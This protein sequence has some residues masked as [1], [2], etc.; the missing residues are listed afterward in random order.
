MGIH[1]KLIRQYQVERKNWYCI[2]PLKY[3]I[4]TFKIC[5]Q[6]LTNSI[7]LYALSWFVLLS[8]WKCIEEL[9]VTQT[10][11]NF[12]SGSLYSVTTI[13]GDKN[14]LLL[15]QHIP[16]FRGNMINCSLNTQEKF[17]A[18]HQRKYAKKFKS[19][20]YQQFA[21]SLRNLPKNTSVST[22]LPA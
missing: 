13:H 10:D 6:N 17:N 19:L 18:A 5:V 3:S 8:L 22:L 11:K 7:S 1:V 16:C 20:P 14:Y 9:P 15:L 21:Q 4:H 2:Y 12:I